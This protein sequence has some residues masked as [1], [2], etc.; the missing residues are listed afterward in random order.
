MKEFKFLSGK[1]KDLVKILNQWRHQFRVEV[2][3]SMYYPQDETGWM[4][5]T[6]EKKDE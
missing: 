1:F 4:L 5:V 2:I 6:R 3:E